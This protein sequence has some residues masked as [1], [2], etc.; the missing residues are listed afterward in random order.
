MAESAK[1]NKVSDADIVPED[2]QNRLMHWRSVST[3]VAFDIGD[4]ANEL[5]VMAS[6]AG[7]P[8]THDRVY[9]AVGRFCGKSGRTVRYYAETSSFYDRGLRN[10]YD[11]LSF[12]HF[13][14]ARSVED[15]RAVL[16]YASEKPQVSVK[17]LRFIFASGSD[18][19]PRHDMR[20]P[21]L[22]IEAD[23]D[24]DRK[25]DECSSLIRPNGG[26]GRALRVVSNLAQAVDDC[27]L[28]IE[29]GVIVLTEPDRA[30]LE[31]AFFVIREKVDML[32]RHHAV[33]V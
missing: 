31:S 8:V 19:E 24:D 6:K 11:H 25:C 7:L 30:S 32:S 23:D 22:W 18:R 33:M 12:A 20:P 2:Y 15:W 5:C 17:E 26:P 1:K 29:E 9:S 13:V 16:D 3:G 4:I 14:F 27:S 28:A 10:L 21:V